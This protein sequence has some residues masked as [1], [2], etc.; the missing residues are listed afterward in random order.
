M[1]R[2]VE[3]GDVVDTGGPE[4]DSSNSERKRRRPAV[5]EFSEPLTYGDDAGGCGGGGAGQT[6]ME[7]RSIG[8]KGDVNSSRRPATIAL[9]F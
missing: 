7:P 1:T 6:D 3:D 9:E 2:L 4:S 5:G 8:E